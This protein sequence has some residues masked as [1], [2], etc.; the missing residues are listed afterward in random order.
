MGQVHGCQRYCSASLHPIQAQQS[1]QYC[2]ILL[3]TMNNVAPII[4]LHPVFN[5]VKQLEIVW[6]C[7]IGKKK[8]QN[9]TAILQPPL[10]AQS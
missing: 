6:P 9:H 10:N 5:N 4:S 7:V 3:K 8:H 2:L 1:Q